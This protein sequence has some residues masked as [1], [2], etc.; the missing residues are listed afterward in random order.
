MLQRLVIL[1]AGGNAY[2]L[3]DTVEAINKT[4]PTWAVV[5]LLDDRREVGTDYLGMPILG[6]LAKATEFA[7]GCSFISSIWNESTSRRLHEI[8]ASTGLRST[9][10]T[11]VFHPDASV[12]RRARFAHG[13][14]M[15][16]GASVA[17]NVTIGDQVS[18]GPGCIIGHDTTLAGRTTVAA[19]AIISGGVKVGSNCYI[20]SGSVIRQHIEIGD[21][22]VIGMGAVV[23]KDVEAGSTV[24]GNPARP[25]SCFS[26]PSA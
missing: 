14:V 25:L 24:V 26:H 9:D 8:I 2:D 22:A 16:H 1:G 17:G 5:G 15:H 21:G 11:N 10:F 13:V 7:A 4:A 23:V 20:G 6:P 12:S 19:G 18:I 3:L